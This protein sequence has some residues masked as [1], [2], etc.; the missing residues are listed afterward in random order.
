MPELSLALGSR[1]GI[2]GRVPCNKLG[3][4]GSPGEEGK[5]A[6]REGLLE[7]VQSKL[8]LQ[9]ASENLGRCVEGRG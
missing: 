1:G 2:I 6:D 5:V 8:T 3:S 7:E 4:T 9:R